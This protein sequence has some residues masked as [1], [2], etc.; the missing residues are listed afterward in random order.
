VPPATGRVLLVAPQP[1]YEDRGTPIAVRQVVEA[2]S[3]LSYDVELLTYPVGAE[4]E[5]PGLEIT[6]APNPLGIRRVPIGLSWRKLALDATLFARLARRVRE[7]RYSC[8]H[9]VEEAA[10]PA[11]VLGRRHGLPVVYDM[12]S[13]LP[14]QLVRHRLF[15]VGAVQR[16]ASRAERWLLDRVDWVVTSTGLAERVRQVAPAT[17]VREWRY[18][19]ALP[20]VSR[21]TTAGLRHELGLAPTA[22]L[23]VYSGSFA[24]YQ[25]L[26]TLLRAIPH[27]RR[28][29]PGATFVLVGARAEEDA[30][31][32]LDESARALLAEGAL[33]IVAR[34][35]RERMAAYLAMA[36]VLVS[37]WRYGGNLPLKIFDYLAAGRPIVATDIPAHRS[38]LD[39]S[40]AVL[41]HQRAEDLA[42]AVVDLLGDRARAERLSDAARQYAAEHLGWGAFVDSVAD[43]YEEVHLGMADA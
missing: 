20:S 15:R 9:A 14:E 40:R 27:I 32:M 19:S 25:G 31:A 28:S 10:F 41:V 7:Q 18:A 38:V 26:S 33:R 11:A 6:R 12:Q 16:S 1:F 21:E 35:P 17:R 30:G 29:V 36:D 42:G 34:Q 22:P 13:S 5:L 39:E 4:V 23:V 37:P 2:L 8:I 43:L 3:Q 24:H